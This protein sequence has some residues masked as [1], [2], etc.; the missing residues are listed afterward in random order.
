LKI[1]HIID[2]GGLYGAEVMLF[3]LVYEQIEMGLEPV[4]ASIG[5]KGIGTK[6]LEAEASQRG[7]KIRKFEMLPGPN[8]AGALAV[9]RYARRERIDLMH[10]HGYKGNILFGLMPGQVR[11]IPIVATLHGYTSTV[12]LT[13]MRLYEWLDTK[14]LK[15]INA[16]VLVSHGMLSN[17]KLKN[18][19]GIDFKIIN[20]GIPP[21]LNGNQ[22]LRPRSDEVPDNADRR[23]IEFCRKGFIIG[24]IGRLSKEKAYSQLIEAFHLIVRHGIDARLVII[25]E[26]HQRPHLEN[27]VSV[28][29]LKGRVLMP[30]YRK[31]AQ[32]YLPY[33]NV[34]VISSLTEGLPITLLEA[35][36]TRTPIVATRVGGIPEAL[37]DGE[38]GLLVPPGDPQVLAATIERVCVGNRSVVDMVDR[39]YKRVKTVFNSQTMAVDYLKIYEE[40]LE[41]KR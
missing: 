21:L 17:L 26:G 13:K 1:L 30:G 29:G 22:S 19:P 31:N 11:K 25:G 4:I 27:V 12:G 32:L 37:E 16:V 15:F 5:E 34:F 18:I 6:P 14:S 7:F 28:L 40:L 20:N 38:A 23:I 2:S 41:S 9:L 35:M 39:S 33:F 3:N 24:A 36:Q 8:I 10:S